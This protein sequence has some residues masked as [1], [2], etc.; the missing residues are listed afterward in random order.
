MG[1]HS[2]PPPG[3]AP[4]VME[5]WPQDGSRALVTAMRKLACFALPFCC[6]A[7]CA[8][9][10]LISARGLLVLGLAALVLILPA[11]LALRGRRTERLRAVLILAGVGAGLLWCAAFDRAVYAPAAAL[12]GQTVRLEGTVLDWPRETDYGDI[13]VTVEVDCGGLFPV[14]AVMYAH[15]SYAGLQPGDR[16]ST[17]AGCELARFRHG[18][19]VTY[20]TA[21]GVFLIV[22]AYGDMTIE[23]PDPVPLRCRPAMLTRALQQGIDRAFA[24]PV[25]AGLARALVAGDKDGLTDQLDQDLRRT[26]LSHVVVVSGMHLSILIWTVVSLLGPNRRRSAAVGCALVLLVMAM[27][28]NTP[29]VVRAGILQLFLL[30]GPLLGRRRDSLTTLTF[31]LM[32][33]LLANP[34]AAASISLQ[35]SF[36]AVLGQYL[37][38]MPIQ[39]WALAHLRLPE[40]TSL[41]RRAW[42]GTGRFLAATLASTLSAQVFTVPLCAWYFGTISLVSPLANLLVLWAVTHAFIGGLAAGILGNLVPALGQLLALPV[43]L[44]LDWI[45]L[46]VTALAKVPFACLTTG[47][48]YYVAWLVFLYVLIV[49]VLLWRGPRRALTPAC[50]CV[51]ALCAAM[52]CTAF[53]FRSGSLTAA[54]LEVG[55]GASTVLR[56]GDQVVLV[57]C[58]GDSYTNPGDI[59]ADYLSDQGVGRLDLLVLTHY[60]DDHANGIPRL[61]ERMEVEVLAVPDVEEDSPLRAQILTQAQA[62]GT[63]VWFIREDCRITMGDGLSVRLFAPFGMGETNEEGLTVLASAGDFDLLLTGDMAGEVEQLLLSQTDLPDLELLF[64]GHHG[65]KYST[66]EELLSALCPEEAVISV[67]EHNLYGHPAPETLTRLEAAGVRVWRTDLNGTVTL[68]VP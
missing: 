26:G 35:L 37:L 38:G 25:N 48:V 34:Y 53:T 54:A 45:R 49:L 10:R 68:R 5:R 24:D 22:E 17:V 64:V 1:Y 55:Q 27:A 52:L 47:S 40:G 61:L 58:G 30:I 11:V 63:R 39:R 32:V 43:S 8:Q 4:Q 20:Y 13:S 57:D 23:R 59:A 15:E 12:D 62:A 9:L 33:L 28:G 42:R 19:E 51:C 2:A 60:H 6:A 41:P 3:G 31:A 50:G 14:S 65:S 67:G 29:S 18:E 36:G 44:L 7:A 16:I 56:L 66:T 46:A 21:K